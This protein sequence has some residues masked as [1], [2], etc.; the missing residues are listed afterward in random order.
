MGGGAY[1]N[2][3][4]DSPKTI[5]NCLVT[6]NTAQNEGAGLF[7]HLGAWAQIENCTIAE[8]TVPG[9]RYGIGGGILCAENVAYVQM[10]NSIVYDNIAAYGPEISAGRLGGSLDRRAFVDVSFSDVQGIWDGVFEDQPYS[11]IYFGDDIYD[12]LDPF[13]LIGGND[14]LFYLRNQE[15]GQIETSALVNGGDVSVGDFFSRAGTDQLTTRIDGVAD[16]GMVDIG[17]HYPSDANAGGI[18]FEYELTIRV[19]TVDGYAAD[20]VIRAEG[21]GFDPVVADEQPQTVMVRGGVQV[22]LAAIPDAGF[23]VLQWTGADYVPN[24]GDPCNVVTMNADKEVTVAFGPQGAFYLY[25]EVTT[26]NGH[27]DYIN[28]VGQRVE[29]PGRTIHDEGEVV[30]L[31]AVP[32]NVVLVPRWTNT[33]DDSTISVE[34]TVTMNTSRFVT[35]SF[36]E[37]TVYYVGQGSSPQ[38]IQN[39]INLA[40]PGDIVMIAPGTWDIYEGLYGQDHLILNGKDITITSEN[41]QE[42]NNTIILGRF[43][44]L[45]VTNNTVIQGFTITGNYRYADRVMPDDPPA[46]MDGLSGLPEHG[47]GMLLHDFYQVSEGHFVKY[48]SGSPTVRNCVFLNCSAIGRNGL[49][50]EPGEENPDGSYSSNGGNGGWGSWA[51]GGAVSCGPDSNPIFENCTFQG[52]FARGGDGG[53]GANGGD[54]FVPGYGGNW[55]D[56]IIPD[57]YRGTDPWDDGPFLPYWRYSGYGGAVYIDSNCSARFIDCNFIDNY[58]QGPSSGISGTGANGVFYAGWPYDHYVIDCYGGAVYAA[59]NSVPVFTDCNFVS[60]IGDNNGIPTH[61]DGGTTTVAYPDLSYGGAIAFEDGANVTLE[62]CTFLDNTADV[63]GG[64]YFARSNPQIIDC[65]MFDNIANHGGGILCVGGSGTIDGC[66]ITGNNAASAGGIGG[67]I[68]SLGANT[69]IRNCEVLA[70]NA[71]SSGGG[72]YISSKGIDGNDV[73]EQ[74]WNMVTVSNCLVTENTAGSSG[75]GVSANWYAYT[76]LEFCTIVNNSVLQNGY[77]GGLYSSYGNYIMVNDSIIWGNAAANGRQIAVRPKNPRAGV[78]VDYSNI[79]G[80]NT[81]TQPPATGGNVWVDTDCIYDYGQGNIGADLDDNPLFVQGILGNYYLSHS[82]IDGQNEDS[83]CIDIGSDSASSYGMN[84]RTTRT[85]EVFDH[86]VVDMG[87]HYPLSNP[88]SQCK[89]CDIVRDGVIDW[90]D[91]EAFSEQWLSDGCS[92]NNGWCQ[93]ADFN[94]D[95]QVDFADYAI[96]G[97][98]WFQRDDQA[99]MPD[100]MEWRILP[101]LSSSRAVS[102]GAAKAY[103]NWGGKVQYYFQCSDPA[104]DSGW[105]FDEPNYIATGLLSGTQYSFRVKARDEWGTLA[106][107]ETLWSVPITVVIAE[108]TTKPLPNPMTWALLPTAVSDTNI[109]MTATVATD[110]SGVEYGFQNVTTGTLVWQDDPTYMQNGLQPSTTY[111][112]K[113]AA[114]DK[115]ENHNT[116]TWSVEASATTT[117]E[118]TPPD[119]QPPVTGVYTNIYKAAFAVVPD[120]TFV[121]GVGWVQTMTAVAAADATPPVQYKFYCY[122]EPGLSSGWLDVPTYQVTVSPPSMQSKDYLKWQVRTR[123]SVVPNPNYG[124]FSDYYN[125]RDQSYPYP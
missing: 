104:F 97:L 100:P 47:G 42:P 96:F 60:N 39:Y 70:N 75:A 22:V 124:D 13:V 27:I 57:P 9:N 107:N 90:F 77:G 14:S 116:T 25:T 12:E 111:T 72:I 53:N 45:N 81:Y 7:F 87:F 99:P 40:Q 91:N 64:V 93:G 26:N 32:N 101:Y 102:M 2:G 5:L 3:F 28:D 10:K 63:G 108:D 94:F 18:D 23:E 48:G 120:E 50:G 1:F 20:G 8:N 85:D 15:A 117:A 41:P 122:D 11:S 121:S 80:G 76:D 113:V 35:V 6:G 98:C 88:T 103:D 4:D 61:R 29:H 118:P 68:A 95:G 125:C 55:G 71:Q 66:R 112:Y 62:G 46:G 16:D 34:N 106:A 105:Q 65:N 110:D 43:E 109:I 33:D 89:F 31:I 51:H 59:A 58:V 19:E 119:L 44:L 78:F 73:D 54:G 123:D 92:Q 67:G 24:T 83:P 115:S 49:D 74:G 82:D 37:P 21:A 79:R 86:G 114:R 30:E 56:N 36:A 84:L 38:M 52:N 69:K 17:Y